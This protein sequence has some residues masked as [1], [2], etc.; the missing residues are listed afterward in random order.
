MLLLGSHIIR[1]YYFY[2]F[3]SKRKRLTF[4]IN[5]NLLSQSMTS[6]LLS[7]SIINHQWVNLT[8]T[9]PE[10]ITNISVHLLAWWRTETTVY[11][12][13]AIRVPPSTGMTA[14]VT[15]APNS[16]TTSTSNNSI[17][18]LQ[19][20]P[21]GGMREVC[22]SLTGVGSKV[23]AYCSDVLG[24][25]DAPSWDAWRN[26]FTKVSQSLFHHFTL[27]KRKKTQRH[28]SF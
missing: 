2:N 13:A 12:A 1:T 6:S 5:F 14:P 11:N 16:T 23:Y 20:N 3:L 4:Q 10:P 24:L 27:V 15:K 28:P 25:A 7:L 26:Y 8:H 9:A 21:N 22:L 19:R 18:V 17:S